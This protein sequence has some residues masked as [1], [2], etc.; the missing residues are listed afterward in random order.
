[1]FNSITYKENK[2]YSQ[3]GQDAFVI[4]YF[5]NKKNGIFV[6]IGA[7]N[8]ISFSN[9]YYLEKELDW[10]GICIE[11]MPK[12]FESLVENRKCITINAAVADKE[13]IEK[14]T[15]ANMLSG[16]TKEYD[17][18]HIKRIQNEFEK[19]EE[20]DMKCVVLNNVLEKYNIYYIDYLNIDTEGNEFKI[21]KTI[22]FNKFDIELITIENNYKDKNQTDFIISKGYEFIGKLG[23]DE[24]FKKKIKYYEK[25]I[26]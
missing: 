23:A 19:T 25:S 11:P 21:V 13:G 24:V 22:D 6:D 3:S 2:I 26:F 7:H 16:L 8:G 4:E 10:S 17:P 14:F 18:R 9:T 20:I 12:S 1:M 15:I 5:Q